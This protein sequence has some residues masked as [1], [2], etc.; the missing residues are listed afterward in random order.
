MFVWNAIPSIT[1]MMSLIFL[2]L[3]LI[4]SIVVTTWPTT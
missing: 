2:L 4:S 3:L 1:P